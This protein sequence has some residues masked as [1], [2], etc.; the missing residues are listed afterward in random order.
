MNFFKSI[1]SDDPDPPHPQKSQEPE[2]NSPPPSSSQDSENPNAGTNP[3]S[4]SVAG[5]SSTT[6][7]SS[8]GGWSFGGLIKTFASQSE[9]V[10]ETYRRDLQEFGSGLRKESQLFREVA[11]RAVKD[12]PA[13]IEV[14]AS[15]AHGSLESVTHAI[16]G[17]IK[18]TAHIISHGED[19]AILSSDVESE[20]PDTSRVS[21]SGRYSRFDAQLNAIQSDV[22]TFSEEPEDLEDY[23]EWKS[24]FPLDEKGEEV[25]NLIGENGVLEGVYRR[26]VPSVVDSETFW[27]RYFY[28][29]HKLKQQ[30][31]VRARLVKRAI[32]ID[33]EEELS[34]DVDDDDETQLDKNTKSKGYEW[35]KKALGEQ[36]SSPIAEQK[37]AGGET[38]LDKNAESKGHE[39]EKKALG[40]QNSSSIVEEKSTGDEKKKASPAAVGRNG[41][42][43]SAGDNVDDN[44]KVVELRE[45]IFPD[46]KTRVEEN[47]PQ[48]K[49]EEKLVEEDDKGGLDGKG[50]QSEATK[51]SDVSVVSR[52]QSVH[53]KK[54]VEED[55]EDM[56]WD[57]IGDI[58]SGDERTGYSNNQGGSPNRADV[59][60]KL[61]AAEE[62]EDL[63][64]D[65]EDDD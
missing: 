8:V 38:Q 42:D 15:V 28:R 9:S 18:S 6:T 22:N 16:D 36:N 62:D 53:D 14:G 23:E 58:G 48:V 46:E 43:K 45:V 54:E 60:E 27:C 1:L 57:E 2:P 25:Q 20:T 34:W 33:D 59:R 40:E 3:S 63:S 7:S 19:A 21:G 29:V 64:W 17:V 41:E 61:S 26:M 47:S 39:L 12:L 56:G 11:S 5:T 49:K 50:D 10:L 51:H 55:E 30:E 31:R 44:S 37:S 4:S 32:S 35:E 24:G 65:I 52:Q 13:S